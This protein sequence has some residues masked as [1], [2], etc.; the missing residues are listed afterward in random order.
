[1]TAASAE[2]RTTLRIAVALSTTLVALLVAVAWVTHSADAKKIKG[3]GNAD[4]LKGT[5]KKDKIKGKGGNDTL[6]GRRGKDVLSGGSGDDLLDAVDNARDK[7]VNGG[8]GTNTC[9]IDQAD[10]PVLTG[11]TKIESPG[12]GG[13]GGGGGG[14][15]GPG[16]GGD[17]GNQLTV[18]SGT[19]LT[20]D[21]SLPTCAF[22]INGSG[23]DAV[24]GTVTGRKGVTAIGGGAEVSTE[25]NGNWTAGGLYGC[26][27]NGFLHVEIGTKSVDV[28]V[29]CRT[30]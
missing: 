19:G 22:T 26:T 10:L 5:N 20:C 30:P 21:S 3:T 17:S 23:A 24:A 14:G 2:Q 18:I 11:C 9:R 13:P 12:G 29:T 1:M 7:R 4:V 6:T 15:G 28:P 25:E 27:A 8:S 16:G